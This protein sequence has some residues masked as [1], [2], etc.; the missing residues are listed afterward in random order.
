LPT[1]ESLAGVYVYKSEDPEGRATDH[2]LDHLVL[3]LDGRYD[4]VQGGSTKAVSGRKGVWTIMPGDPPIV[5]LDHAGYP[6]QIRGNEVRLLIDND[7][8][9]WYAKTN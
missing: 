1:R 2:D 5:D 4:L 3:Q 9:I 7:V 6:I 8:G